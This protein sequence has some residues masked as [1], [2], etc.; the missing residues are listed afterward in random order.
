MDTLL[1]M[2]VRPFP[3]ALQE[4]HR[5]WAAWSSE[6]GSQTGFKKMEKGNLFWK[7]EFY[8]RFHEASHLLHPPAAEFSLLW[9]KHLFHLWI[10][11]KIF[12]SILSIYLV[13]A[14]RKEENME[15]W[16]QGWGYCF[17]NLTRQSMKG[18]W[19]LEIT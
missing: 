6:L 4:S 9:K 8:C 5:I 1:G 16:N 18:A 7:P 3:N 10:Q 12:P 2:V 15:N 13:I 11:N 14:T 17:E 19:R